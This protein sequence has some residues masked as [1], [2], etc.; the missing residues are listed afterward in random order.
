MQKSA[1]VCTINAI[2]FFF[3]QLSSSKGGEVD[4]AGRILSY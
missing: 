3:S 2:L 1:T 4:K